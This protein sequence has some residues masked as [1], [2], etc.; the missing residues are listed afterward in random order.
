MTTHTMVRPVQKSWKSQ[1]TMEGAGV[2]LKRAFGFQEM[3]GLDPFLLMDDFRSEN[4]RDY[5]AGFPWHPHRGMETITYVLEGDVEH[6]DSLGNSGLISTG[7]VR[8]KLRVS[9][10]DDGRATALNNA[11]HSGGHARGRPARRRP[12]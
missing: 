3:P 11:R 12:P 7:D 8:T 5:Q 6:S 1:P 9:R 2:H 4:P 10:Y